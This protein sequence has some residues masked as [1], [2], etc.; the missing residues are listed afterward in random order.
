MKRGTF[1]IHVALSVCLPLAVAA[2]TGVG[3]HAVFAGSA[4]ETGGVRRLQA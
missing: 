3:V 1:R 2:L 4:G